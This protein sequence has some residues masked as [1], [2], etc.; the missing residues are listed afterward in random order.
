VLVKTCCENAS[1]LE[2]EFASRAQHLHNTNPEEGKGEKVEHYRG[3]VT[4]MRA[5]YKIYTMV[6]ERIRE[7]VEKKRI[8]PQKE[9]GDNR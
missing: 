1:S 8:V 4:I 6:L 3:R 7:E 9:N 5:L 2:G